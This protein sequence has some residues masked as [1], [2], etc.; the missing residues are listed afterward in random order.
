MFLYILILSLTGLGPNGGLVYCLEYLISHMDWLMDQI[1]DYTDDYLIIDCPG[2]I[3]LY[4]HLPGK[5][6]RIDVW[7]IHIAIA[8]TS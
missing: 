5:S 6:S 7:S 4:T 2:Q 1:A 3:E 8:M